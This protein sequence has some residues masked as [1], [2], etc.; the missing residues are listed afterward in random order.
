M[1]SAG[2]PV[3]CDAVLLDATG[4]LF[5]PWPSVGA[6]YAAVAA[7]HGVTAVPEA[8]EAGFRAAWRR[9]APRRFA[10]DPECRTSD[11][12]EKAWWRAAV[13]ATFEHAGLPDPG[14]ACFE[15][16]FERFAEAACWRLFPDVEPVLACLRQAGLCVGVVSNFDSRLH[17]ICAGLGLAQRVDFVVASAEVGHGKPA[18]QIFDIAVREA[19]TPAARTLMVG[20][21]PR[22]D[23]AGARAAGCLALWLDRSRPPSPH[24]L[25]DLSRLP[26]LLGI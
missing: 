4:T 23:V 7:E 6:V 25:P 8:L 19:G 9:R 26:P 22:D 1:S 11:A 5:R 15:A 10:D 13:A 2:P 24:A 3:S 17:R 21:S 18:R 12:Q 16:I 14:D 20:D